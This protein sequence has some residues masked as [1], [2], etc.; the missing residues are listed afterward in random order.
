MIDYRS[1]G[2]DPSRATRA[3]AAS[4]ARIASTCGPSVIENPGGFGGLYGLTGYVDPVL[5]ATTDGV[6]TKIK[7]AVALD[8]HDTI[9]VDLVAMCANDILAE[10]ARPLFFLDYVAAARIVPQRIEAILQGIAAGCDLAGCALLGGETAEQPGVYHD[11]DYD[12][13]GFAVGC[14]ERGGLLRNRTILKGDVLLGIASS[15]LHSN[16]FSLVRKVLEE[17]DLASRP[18]LLGGSTLG[19]VL[20]EPTRVYA[21]SLL[22]V[23]HNAALREAVHGLSHV[24]GGGIPG[25][26]AR[27]LPDGVGA[28]VQ[29]ETWPEPPIMRLIETSGPV[30][31][32]EMFRVFNMGI[33]MVAVVASDRAPAITDELEKAGEKVW[34]IGT[35]VEGDGV[36]IS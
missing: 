2:V 28:E 17:H 24:T 15:G 1:A 32:D 11:G 23:L 19:T 36:R 13:A 31:R 16:G 9:G 34:P 7:L 22:R 26:L 8:H 6:G 25:N 27:I 20:L 3:L 18:H 35:V 30:A 10:G 21:R 5:V 4:A 14:V 12:L 29:T 33:G